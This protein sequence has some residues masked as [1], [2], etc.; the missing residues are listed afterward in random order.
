MTDG[1]AAGTK[2]AIVIERLAP[3]TDCR[4]AAGTDDRAAGTK[5]RE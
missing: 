4:R 3:N 2:S 5:T 1:R